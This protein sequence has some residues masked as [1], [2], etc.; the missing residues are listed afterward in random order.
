MANYI[1]DYQS[2]SGRFFYR[3]RLQVYLVDTS[4]GKQR[5]TTT[6]EEDTAY[7][8]DIWYQKTKP[9]P[10]NA[11]YC[12]APSMR[13]ALFWLSDTRYLLVEVPF[14]SSGN[15]YFAFYYEAAL[16]LK[17]IS[18]TIAVQGETIDSRRLR[19]NV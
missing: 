7:L 3:V 8:P 15:D 5:I 11:I 2:D 12:E 19:L 4:S 14:I 16:K 17:E 1:G 13:S 6:L 10:L 9:L 18:R